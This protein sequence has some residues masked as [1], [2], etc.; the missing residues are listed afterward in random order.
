MP[1]NE[2]KQQC[3]ATTRAG[4]RCPMWAMQGTDAQHGRL[5]CAGHVPDEDPRKHYFRQPG[6]RRRCV[7]KTLDGKRCRN[8]TLV[9]EAGR[10]LCWMHA[11]PDQHARIRHSYYRQVPHFTDAQ[12]AFIAAQARQGK[13]LA[14]ELAVVRLKLRG[15]LSYLKRP[16]L[17]AAQRVHA[18]KLVFRGVITVSRLPRAQKGLVKIDWRPST[19]GR[20]PA[21]LERIVQGDSISNEMKGEHE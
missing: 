5:L 8:W 1:R 13:P 4:N 6:E 14:A 20:A 16:E 10:G 15:L 21:L 11:Y 3:T 7:A 18:A 12:A 9:D 17:P 2:N 19:A